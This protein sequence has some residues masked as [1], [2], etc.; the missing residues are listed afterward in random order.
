MKRLATVPTLAA[1]VWLALVGGASAQQLYR[2][3]GP[4]GRV[5]FSDRP[6]AQDTGKTS[7]VTP[8]GASSP[9]ANGNLPFELREVVT[10]YPVTLYTTND[11]GPCGQ[12]RTMLTQRGVPFI[13]RTVTT[14]EDLDALKRISGDTSLPFG[15]IG[16]QQ[17]QGYSDA[18]WS[19][20]LDAA[21]YPKASQL[22]P[23]FRQQPAAPLVAAKRAEPTPAPRPAAA[24]PA[25]RPA[26]APAP[27]SNPSNP[28]GIQ[29]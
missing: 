14:N 10:R 1:A 19:Q 29:F 8:G 18:E 4:D 6:P 22:P 24:A 15:T 23:N 21:G 28:A 5:T 17:L 13:E 7:T 20:Y 9:A 3:V 2:S 26:A 27:A 16:G 11:C 12:A 25:P